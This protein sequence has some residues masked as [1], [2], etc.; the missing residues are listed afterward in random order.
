MFFRDFPKCIR[1]SNPH[2]RVSGSARKVLELVEKVSFLLDQ[3]RMVFLLCRLSKASYC[4]ESRE[5]EEMVNIPGDKPI[6]S[7]WAARDLPGLSV[8]LL[9]QP[10]EWKVYPVFVNGMNGY[11]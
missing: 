5:M 9:P 2:P 10:L 6:S 8:Y 7:L 4:S 3:D 11:I 1:V